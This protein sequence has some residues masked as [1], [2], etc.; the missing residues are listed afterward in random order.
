MVKGMGAPV[1]L[2]N[3][4]MYKKPIRFKRQIQNTDLYRNQRAYALMRA[5]HKCEHCGAT[6]GELSPKG[7]LIKQLDM[8]HIVPFD[9]IVA[10]YKITSLAQARL[11]PKLWDVKLVKILCHDC[12]VD[13]DESYGTGK[14]KHES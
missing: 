12:H 9:E 2:R 5:N 10:E 13:E 4:D 14:L 11:C 6:V 3:K 1:P 7:N 8:H